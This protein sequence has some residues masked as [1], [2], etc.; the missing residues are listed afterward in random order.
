MEL[1]KFIFINFLLPPI[2]YSFFTFP[3]YLI[4]SSPFYCFLKKKPGSAGLQ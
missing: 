2:L 4:L 1:G 3:Y